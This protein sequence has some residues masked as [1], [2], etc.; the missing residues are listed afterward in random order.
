MAY[1]AELYYDV[2]LQRFTLSY[3]ILEAMTEKSAKKEAL[4]WAG[5]EAA[6][7]TRTAHLRIVLNGREL[8]LGSY[9]AS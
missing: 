3:K 9:P 8:Y 1:F 7:F 4:E 2:E 6:L 5:E